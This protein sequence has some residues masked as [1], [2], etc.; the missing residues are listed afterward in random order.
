MKRLAFLFSLILSLNVSIGQ[1][2]NTS[3]LV[4]QLVQSIS[5]LDANDLLQNARSSKADICAISVSFKY[6]NDNPPSEEVMFLR[7]NDMDENE[8]DIDYNSDGEEWD[9]SAYCNNLED[10]VLVTDVDDGN[11]YESILMVSDKDQEVLNRL[12]TTFKQAVV[13]CKNE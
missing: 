2:Q 1:V 12:K 5:K 9:L 6:P 3:S 4:D 11:Y 7:L 8:I 10:R 13:A